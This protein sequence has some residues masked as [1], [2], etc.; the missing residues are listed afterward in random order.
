MAG[1]LL[2]IFFGHAIAAT[3]YTF[4]DASDTV[5]GG[6]YFG[7]KVVVNALPLVA[8]LACVRPRG[9]RLP[10]GR[11]TSRA[12]AVG[13]ATGVFIAAAIITLYHTAFAGHLDAAKLPE[14]VAAYGALEHFFLLAPFICIINS[15]LEEYYWR[16]FLFGVLCRLT[17]LPIAV[18]LSAASFTL[19]H[20][21]IVS[22]YFPSAGMVALLNLGVFSGGIIWA[23]VYHQTKSLFAP[24]ISHALTDAGI[25]VVAHDLLFAA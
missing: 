15:A 5:R 20:V 25:F 6:L 11:P 17:P 12:L 22:A 18:L 8:Y 16:W 19:H 2:V 14:K 7:S 23:V 21:V 24:W 13:I 9:H 1:L 3:V 4:L 10:I